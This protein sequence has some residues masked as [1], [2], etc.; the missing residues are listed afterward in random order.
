MGCVG[1]AMCGD[2]MQN[3]KSWF[4]ETY[5]DCGRNEFCEKCGWCDDHTLRGRNLFYVTVAF[6]EKCWG[7][8]EYQGCEECE[9]CG[10]YQ[11]CEECEGC[12][13]HGGVNR[14]SLG[15][16]SAWKKKKG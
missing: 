2:R 6:C 14:M 5:R 10:E 8:G 4:Y 1:C 13:G 12:E 15:F 11:G 9:G 3:G 7:W 16:R